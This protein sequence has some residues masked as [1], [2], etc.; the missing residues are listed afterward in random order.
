[1]SRYLIAGGAG[2][3]G[4]NAADHYARAGHNVT[5]L[6]NFSRRGTDIN[7][8]WLLARHPKVRVVRAARWEY[9]DL[10]VHASEN[11]GLLA[12]IAQ[13]LYPRFIYSPVWLPPPFYASMSRQIDPRLPRLTQGFGVIAGGKARYYPISVIPMEGLEDAWGARILHIARGALDGVPQA[14][15]KDTGEFPMQLLSRWYGFS[16][17]YPYCEIYEPE[18]SH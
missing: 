5:I 4:V 1:M 14:R 12:C 7:A 8:D 16:F 9:P 3:I 10:I 17:T 6:D 15:W 13:R 18:I 11:H 2:F